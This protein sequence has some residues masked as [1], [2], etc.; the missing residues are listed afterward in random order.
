M[1]RVTVLLTG[2]LLAVT[3]GCKS[4]PILPPP[5]DGGQKA[6]GTS[7]CNPAN[8]K[9]CCLG[10]AC[11]SGTSRSACGWGGL[12]CVI[13]QGNE[14]CKERQCVPYTGQCDQ[15][16][17]PNGC[18]QDKT[19]KPG[20]DNKN[21][22]KGGKACV[23]CAPDKSCVGGACGLSGACTAANC[24][25]CCSGSKC[26][27]GTGDQFCGK[28]GQGCKACNN[29]QKCTAGVCKAYAQCSPTNCAGCC[30][31]TTCQPGTVF[32]LCGKGGQ[33]CKPCQTGQACNAGVCGVPPAQCTPA[34]CSG[35][36]DGNK[37][38]P[39]ATNTH[40]GYGGIKCMPCSGGKVCNKGTC[41][42]PPPTCTP[43]NCSGCCSG[44]SCNPGTTATHCGAGGQQCKQCSGGKVCQFGV[45]TTPRPTCGPGNCSGCCSGTTCISSTS[46]SNCGVA[47]AKC[48]S[49][50]K[51][52]K[53][54]SGNCDLDMYSKWT[55]TLSY[56]DLLTSKSWD[57]GGK[58]DAYGV[59][60]L[61]SQSKT[62]KI[63]NDTYYPTWNEY[64]FNATASAIVSL[65]LKVLLRDSDVTW[66]QDIGTCLIS[67]SKSELT[68]GAK[69][70]YNC[71]TKGYITKIKIKFAP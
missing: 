35:C 10:D 52:Q 40:C 38:Q 3:V 66:D 2:M 17:C 4:D 23:A 39:G 16:T 22:G 57:M 42:T 11:L 36:C 14:S 43:A 12:A 13:C 33:A 69:F 25:G 37:C 58:P 51:Y 6:D 32:H 29:L 48:K 34:N 71:D 49:C 47:G 54:T 9:G 8:C 63:I 64:L 18:C 44:G 68:S 27:P 46:T 50:A 20:V 31:G 1:K 56:A 19:C 70:V 28:G 26:H 53:C 62:T 15:F 67:T 55:V 30:S 24:T 65:Q 60:T 41:G 59:V 61:G 45:C 21:C 5:L 7:L